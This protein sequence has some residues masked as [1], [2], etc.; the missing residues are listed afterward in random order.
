MSPLRKKNPRESLQS[1]QDGPFPPISR[2]VS[3][4]SPSFISHGN[5]DSSASSLYFH[6][7]GRD[8]VR[9]SAASSAY[10]V[11]GQGGS[12][13]NL[14]Q[15]PRPT[16]LHHNSS[17]SSLTSDFD[18]ATIVQTPNPEKSF[19][20]PWVEGELSAN[21]FKKFNG[22]TNSFFKNFEPA[23]YSIETLNKHDDVDL[24]VPWKRRMYRLSPFFT[25]LACGSYFLYY[26]YRIH[27]TIV[28][29]QSYQK[30]YVMAWLFIAAEGCVACTY[31]PFWSC[32]P[33]D[34]DRPCFAPSN[35][36]NACHPWPC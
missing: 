25:F 4:A 6:Q 7:P 27:C 21:K 32:S 16:Y 35:V 33:A 30:T 23:S 2:P 11:N 12:S 8:S 19:D 18:G 28:A 13:V 24:L 31:N 36:P 1:P 26:A 15:Y 20:K 5:R 14:L 34:D 17:T 10:F 22:S 3:P 29:Q 9:D